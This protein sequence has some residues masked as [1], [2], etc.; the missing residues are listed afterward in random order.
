MDIR[1]VVAWNIRRLRVNKQ[2]SQEALASEADLDRT[3]LSRLEQSTE[4]PS[5]LTLAAIAKALGVNPS[6]LFLNPTGDIQTLPIL[7]A[8]RRR[9]TS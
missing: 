4:N 9:R 8:G 5:I 2:L 1:K 3:Y 6:E 7:K